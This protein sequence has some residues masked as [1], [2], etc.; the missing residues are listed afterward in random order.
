M[1]IWLIAAAAAAVAVWFF[2]LFLIR[3]RPSSQTW[4]CDWYYAHRGLHSLEFPEN[5]MGAFQAACDAGFGI[6]LDVHL[7]KDGKVVVVHDHNLGRLAGRDVEPEDLTAAELADLSIL[8][9]GFGVPT[10]QEVL[11]LVRGR[12][13]LLIELKN[14]GLSGPLEVHTY[15][16]LKGYGGLYAL[17]SFSPF[18]MRWFMKHEPGRLRGQLSCLHSIEHTGVHW[19]PLFLARHLLTDWICRPNFISYC[20]QYIDASVTRRLRREG[21]PVLAWTVE[22]AQEAQKAAP[23]CDTIIFQSFDPREVKLDFRAAQR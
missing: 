21:V 3:C 2:Y 4:L 20:R 19:F 5:T 9:S 14:R 8:G 18:S 1:I 17:Q 6:E 15:E 12:V 7:S 16:E 13:P 10:L 22:S 23:Y 11:R